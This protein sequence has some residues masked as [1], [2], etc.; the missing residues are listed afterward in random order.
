MD[1]KMFNS[2]KEFTSGLSAQHLQPES[3]EEAKS[4]FVKVPPKEI[5]HEI[6]SYLN[7]E[8]LAK[9]LQVNKNWK[10]LANHEALWNAPT[11]TLP[12][13]AFGKKQWAKYFGDIGKAPPLSK[14]I[15]KILKS[16]CPFWPEKKVE[17]THMLVLIPETVNGKPLNLITLGKLVKAPKVVVKYSHFQ[18]SLRKRDTQYEYIWDA[19]INE[20]GHQT[21][22]K[23]HWVLMTKD[24]IKGSRNKSYTDQQ[25]LIAAFAKRTEINYEIPNVLDTAI[26][27][28]MYYIHFGERLFYTA[29]DQ[30][31]FTHC[32]ETSSGRQVQVVVGGLSPAGLFVCGHSSFSDCVGVVAVQK[33]F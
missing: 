32:R 6:F 10:V 15:H 1:F 18:L 2:I 14:S 30:R 21:T 5:M 11:S 31:I 13:N 27:I 26:C 17:E 25:A 7:A 16:P 33:F 9:C 3:C 19:V 23:S 12:K 4:D 24:V 28:F 29:N 8:E 22:A 20:H